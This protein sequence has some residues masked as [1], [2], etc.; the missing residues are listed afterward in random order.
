MAKLYNSLPSDIIGVEDNYTAFCFNEACAYI[1]NRLQ[2]GDKI[3]YEEEKKEKVNK[4]YKSF[5]DFYKDI[6][7]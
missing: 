1:T 6:G 4:K 2:Q 3:I 7:T 5:K